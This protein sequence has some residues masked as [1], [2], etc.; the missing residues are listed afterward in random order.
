MLRINVDS[1]GCADHSVLRWW[2]NDE[3]EG[4]PAELVSFG[5]LFCVC[6]LDRI[7]GQVWFICIFLSC[8]NQYLW[9][10]EKFYWHINIYKK[11]NKRQYAQ[12]KQ[13]IHLPSCQESIITDGSLLLPMLSKI[14]TPGSSIY[15][16]KL[17][18]NIW[19]SPYVIGLPQAGLY[20][21]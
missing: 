19:G 7:D 3:E 1:I 14:T 18:H 12:C 4:G 21:M 5:Y 11:I 10:L 9:G 20:K 8:Q 15:W 17:R 16:H 6:G 13:Q 2:I